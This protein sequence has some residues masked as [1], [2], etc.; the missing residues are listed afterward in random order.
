MGERGQ[1]TG[2]NRDAALAAR[3]ERCGRLNGLVELVRLQKLCSE[4][5]SNIK[6]IG[7]SLVE[8]G[9]DLTYEQTQK[10]GDARQ[11]VLD[12]ADCL[13]SVAT[14]LLDDLKKEVG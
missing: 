7:Q 4:I 5:S 6:Y 10:L 3:R 11:D 8:H 2:D 1:A 12:A 14:E 13:H 9:A